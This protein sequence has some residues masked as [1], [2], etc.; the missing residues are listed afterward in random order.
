[1]NKDMESSGEGCLGAAFSRKFAQH[2]G[3]REP[4]FV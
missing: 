4:V 2:L 1:M 3:N